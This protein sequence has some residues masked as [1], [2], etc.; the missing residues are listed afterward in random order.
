MILRVVNKR[1][2]G[3]SEVVDEPGISLVKSPEPGFYVP[4]VQTFLD[5]AEREDANVAFVFTA[6]SAREGVSY[7]IGAVARELAAVTGEKVLVA[8]A[9]AIGNFAPRHDVEPSEPVLREGNGVYRLRPPQSPNGATRIERFTLLR[10]L[11]A[12]FPFVLID[13]PALD[14]SSEAI[15]FAAR[16]KGLVLV[17][18]AGSAQRS[19]LVRAKGMVEAAGVDLLGCV[20]N[21]RT[22]PIPDFLYRRL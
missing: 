12:L 16:E 21:R 9:S 4:L 20:V 17:V 8:D 2:D 13:A 22:Y 10:Q 1:P 19:R 14:A 15:E 11:K 5:I 7:V 6:S 3:R 18:G